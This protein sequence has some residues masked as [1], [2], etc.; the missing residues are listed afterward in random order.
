MS[1]PPCTHLQQFEMNVGDRSPKLEELSSGRDVY[2]SGLEEKKK[3]ILHF[4]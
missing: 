1:P 2:C 3:I 4:H